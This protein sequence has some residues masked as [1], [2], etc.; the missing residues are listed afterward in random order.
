V[1]P[2]W[3]TPVSG[4]NRQVKM[5]ED[6]RS[7]EDALSHAPVPDAWLQLPQTQ[8]DAMLAA[9]RAEL[10]SKAELSAQELTLHVYGLSGGT[11]SSLGGYYEYHQVQSGSD[12]ASH[13]IYKVVSQFEDL[14]LTSQTFSLAYYATIMEWDEPDYQPHEVFREQLQK[15]LSS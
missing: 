15:A 3:D 14:K 5:A 13:C 8:R 11:L 9:V 12:Y 7:H 2:W 4:E 1:F 6:G 10:C